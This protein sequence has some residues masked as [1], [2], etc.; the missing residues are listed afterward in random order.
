MI[1]ISMQSLL[2]SPKF[3]TIAIAAI[4]LVAIPLTI[5]Q[6]QNRQTTQQQADT[7]DA[8]WKTDQS[9]STI[10]ADNATDGV[11]IKA[12]FKNTEPDDPKLYMDVVVK[13]Q[14]TGKQV[15]MGTVK[16]GQ[17]KTVEIKTGKAS[18]NSGSVTFYLEWTNAG[19]DT[20]SRTAKYNGTSNCNPPTP[21]NKPTKV[22]TPTDKPE[23]PT[24]TP[25]PSPTKKPT[26][27]TPPGEPTPTAC[28][29]LGPVQ[30]VKIDCPNCE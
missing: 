27:T 2:S 16:G 15:D 30:N 9:A 22:P 29:T 1:N 12:T 8:L 17:S 13:D 28:P 23:E 25:T 24:K 6:V 19:S 10:C 18:L 26:P 20:D 7:V 21:T 3:I 14:Q 4:A 5:V 11:I